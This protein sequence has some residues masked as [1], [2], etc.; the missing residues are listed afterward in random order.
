MIKSRPTMLSL[1][2]NNNIF[3]LLHADVSYIIDITCHWTFFFQ[4]YQFK[5][6]LGMSKPRFFFHFPTPNFVEQYHQTY[7]HQCLALIS[8]LKH[9]ISPY[10]GI[11]WVCF[12][13]SSDFL[14]K[15]ALNPEI[16]AENSENFN[17]VEDIS[18]SGTEKH[19]LVMCACGLP[20]RVYAS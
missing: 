14:L 20:S 12:T 3:N 19:M 6:L 4:Y 16:W 15:S 11:V 2:V 9:A 10:F 1:I 8:W 18:D 13:I 7:V 17:K 5:L